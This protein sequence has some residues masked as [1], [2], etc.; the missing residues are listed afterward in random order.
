MNSKG[1]GRWRWM[2]QLAALLVLI[3]GTVTAEAGSISGTVNN[4]SD[5]TGRV[6]ISLQQQYGGDSGFGVSIAPTETTYAI[7]GVPNG[8]YTLK[9][10][11]DGSSTGRLHSNDPTWGPSGDITINN[12]SYTG[13]NSNVTF[14]PLSMVAPVTPLGVMIIPGD[15]GAFVGWQTLQDSNGNTIDNADFYR[16]YYSTTNSDPKAGGVY[17]TVPAGDQ[18][19]AIFHF[20]NGSP[21]YVSVSALVDTTESTPTDVATEV[22]NPPAAGFSISG[23]INLPGISNPT[24]DL[25]IALVDKSSDGGGPV[26]VTWVANPPQLLNSFTINTNSTNVPDGTYSLFALI[27]RDGDG[28]MGSGDIMPNEQ[29]APT[30]V[31]TGTD[32]PGQTVTLT[33]SNSSP[34]LTTTHSQDSST[35]PYDGYQ[36]NI[37]VQSASESPVNITVTNGPNSNGL[38]YPIDLGISSWGDYQAWLNVNSNRPTPVTDIYDLSIQ[39]ANDAVSPDAVNLPVTAVLDSFATPTAP[40]GYLPYSSIT[41]PSIYSWSAPATPPSPYSYSFW[42]NANGFNNNNDAYSN[43]ASGTTFLSIPGLTYTDG[44]RYDWSINVQDNYGNQAQK[45][46]WFAYTT[47]PAIISFTPTTVVPG[48]TVTISGINFSTTPA[49]NTVNF[50][51]AS[52]LATTASATQIQVV[53]PQNTCPSGSIQVNANGQTSNYSTTQLNVL[54]TTTISGQATEIDTFNGISGAIVTAFYTVNSTPLTS[55]T[56][57]DLNGNYTILSGVPS[58]VDFT[59]DATATGYDHTYTKILNTNRDGTYQNLTLFPA[60]NFTAWNNGDTTTGIIRGRVFDQS[61]GSGIMGVTINASIGTVLYD[62]GSGNTPIAGSST[63]SNGIFYIKSVADNTSVN[64]IAMKAGYYINPVSATAHAGAITSADVP[65]FPLI[66]IT[67]SVVNSSNSALAGATIEQVSTA[68]SVTSIA[69]GAFTINNIPGNGF[70]LKM[71]L[72]PTYVPTYTGWLNS[73]NDLTLPSPYTLFTPTEVSTVL[74]ISSGKGAIIGRLVNSANPSVT[75]SGGTVAASGT[76]PSYVIR[77]FDS[78]SQQFTGTMATDASGLFLVRDV[79]DNGSVNLNAFI[80]TNMIGSLNVTTHAPG[81]SEI[82]IS[83]NLP[84]VGWGNLQWPASI[85]VTKNQ[86]T[87]NIYGQAYMGGVT[88]AAPGPAAGLV[89]EVGYGPQG[90][91][92]TDPSWAWTAAA[93]NTSFLWVNNRHEFVAT[94]SVPTPGSYDYAFRYSYLGGS[95][96]YGDLDGSSN[97]Y[98]P[99]QAGK[100]TVTAPVPTTTTVVSDVNTSLYGQAVTFTANITPATVTGSIQFFDGAI[101]L[102][103]SSLTAGSTTLQISDLPVGAHN[104][105]AIYS[106]DASYA[107]NTSAGV[108]QTVDDGVKIGST[109]NFLTLQGAVTTALDTNSLLLR[110]THFKE[111][112]T[113]NRTLPFTITLTGGLS[114]DFTTPIGTT[115]VRTLTIKQGRVNAVRLVVKPD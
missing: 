43:L 95:Y 98:S 12:D 48:M 53:V 30:V 111:D 4:T 16:V 108:S 73:S 24:G 89:A 63:N 72:E 109:G 77:Y 115:S 92:P 32:S 103:A 84:T 49:N 8:T 47:S 114:S 106:G 107:G 75:I 64:I 90:S 35:P 61:N 99:A 7:R 60:G 87:E 31:I 21:L 85:N 113:I 41:D 52:T 2:I 5:R 51:G 93:Y 62:D 10:F 34:S 44:Q 26:A 76:S 38:S 23:T 13:T 19:F 39:Y 50:C 46:S 58:G 112:I 80:G 18:D 29:L 105:T 11:V 66:S 9:A 56:T 101:S 3:V 1:F 104:I 102:G 96:V 97:G 36:I 88:D 78:A 71:S 28:K 83:C 74:G 17:T 59:M 100:L 45:S 65:G 86:T 91:D 22:I 27:D 94:I 55:S 33:Q 69:G 82:M 42:V 67:G 20:P 57:T 68:N 15:N 14:T 110:D 79:T 54:Q 81:V 40:M 25:Y 37:R 6:F 70:E